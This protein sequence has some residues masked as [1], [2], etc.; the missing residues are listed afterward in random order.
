MLNDC[1]YE[2]VHEQAAKA[3]PQV[4]QLESQ[5]ALR[6]ASIQADL[7]AQL[8]QKKRQLNAL[9]VSKLHDLLEEVGGIYHLEQFERLFHTRLGSL[10]L[11]EFK[12]CGVLELALAEKKVVVFYPDYSRH[13][14]D[15]RIR[16]GSAADMVP[17]SDWTSS[18]GDSDTED[19]KDGGSQPSGDQSHGP[20]S[21]PPCSRGTA[22]QRWRRRWR[23]QRR[24]QI[25]NLDASGMQ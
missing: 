9:L 13:D 15:R 11:D 23:P 10:C 20:S 24:E 22:G 6:L 3:E 25:D 1:L 8:E 7:E 12:F 5:A 14:N 2:P 19:D 17:E 16:F 18:D 21:G 4:A